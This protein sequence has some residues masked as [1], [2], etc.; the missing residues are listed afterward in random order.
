MD[1]PRSTGSELH[2]EEIKDTNGD[3]TVDDGPRSHG[4]LQAIRRNPWAFAWCLYA[5]STLLLAVYE[6]QAS[7]AILGI[8]GFRRDFG[9]YYEGG[10]VLAASWQSAFQGAPI[11]TRVVGALTAAPVAD[12]IGRRK[13]LMVA[14]ALSL[15]AITMEFV[16][17]TNGL[18]FGAKLL[19]GMA[20]AAIEA[21][22]G[23]YLAEAHNGIV[24]TALRGLMTVLLPFAA[25]FGAL[26]AALIIDSSGNQPNRWAYR[27]VFCSQYAFAAVPVIFIWFMPESPWWLLSK[28]REDQALDSLHR[29]GYSTS[30]GEDV[31]RLASIKVTLEQ[32]RQE[33]E[34][35][36]YLECFRRSNLRRTIVATAP[37]S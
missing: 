32:I 11:A 23:T 31:N 33:T 10:Y 29:L 13:T 15:V 14:V 37:L 3:V 25:G 35:V 9:S 21:V 8:P 1:I 18:F 34:G 19:S 27:T 26:V 28:G 4:R 22:C 36:T 24:P 5:V 2:E 17:T 16:A 6:D 30:R 20:V 12:Y 7:Y